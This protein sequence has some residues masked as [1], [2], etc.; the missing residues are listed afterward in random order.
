MRSQP[1]A[2]T[3]LAVEVPDGWQP[4][5][6]A[7]MG[8]ALAVCESEPEGEFATN[9]TVVITQADSDPDDQVAALRAGLEGFQLL[10]QAEAG[11]GWRL[12]FTHADGG[13]ELSALQH[14]QPLDGGAG[15]AVL[16]IT[17]ATPRVD[18]TAD[19]MTAIADS[20]GPA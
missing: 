6:G 16:T 1:I 19:V 3:G 4:I 15:T 9:L 5:D 7:P 17:A 13:H 12:W 8:C 2:D 14:H 10:D 11:E 18:D 20:L